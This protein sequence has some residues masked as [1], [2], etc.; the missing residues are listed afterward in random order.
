MLRI[1]FVC[2]GH[3]GLVPG[4]NVADGKVTHAAVAE[5]TGHEYTPVN[6]VIG[7]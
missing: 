4:V 2:H 7:D 6:D 5:A 3:P 1:L